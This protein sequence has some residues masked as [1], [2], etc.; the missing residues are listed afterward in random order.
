MAVT[1]QTLVDN[2][3]IYVTEMRNTAIA[4]LQNLYNLA[5][6]W[7]S[8][9]TGAV[10]LGG[11]YTVEGLS[12]VTQLDAIT[13][14]P[15][16]LT[17]GAAAT[18]PTYGTIPEFEVPAIVTA[19][20]GNLPTFST[21]DMTTIVAPTLTLEP[22][23]DGYTSPKW[24][25]AAWEQLKLLLHEFSG[26]IGGSDS[27]DTAITKLT[28]DT[29]K[30]QN[31]LYSADVDRKQQVLRDVMSAI[32]S[33]TGAKG[34]S[35]PNMMTNAKHIA[36]QQEYMFELN[37]ISMVLIDRLMVWAKEAYHFA[38]EQ[39]MSAH[40]MDVEFN[41][42]Y[43][44]TLLQ[45]YATTLNGVIAKYKQDVEKLVA[46]TELEL[47]K[48]AQLTEVQLKTY[49]EVANLE[50]KKFAAEADNNI[51]AEVRRYTTELELKI[52]KYN[53]EAEILIRKHIA[54]YDVA[55]SKFG[56]DVQSLVGCQSER[57]KL[58]LGQYTTKVQ[59]ASNLVQGAATILN[60]HSQ[61]ILGIVKDTN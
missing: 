42:K 48:Y 7:Q 37:K 51:N 60:S 5:T 43:A 23:L 47:K 9:F 58:E 24:N 17:V 13:S 59:A 29:T 36:T 45:S 56:H 11:K 33:N 18:I 20:L 40:N 35:H 12:G 14:P 27:V 22:D 52:K 34:F 38:I 6:Q 39:Q 49:T 57:T 2:N 61:H 44:N 21:G 16:T 30:L 53:T 32:S 26:S 8:T 15:N 54:E 28:S 4:A 10:W 19:A 46:Y 31:A 41:I 50:L 1:N 25:E 3:A 55:I